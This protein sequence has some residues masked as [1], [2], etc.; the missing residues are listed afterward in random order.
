MVPVPRYPHF[1]PEIRKKNLS[2]MAHGSK[3]D[4][5]ICLEFI[6]NW[7]TLSLETQEILVKKEVQLL[8]KHY[9]WKMNLR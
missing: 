8:R 7:E 2:G 9:I 5:Q 3:L 1:D 6:N 4:E